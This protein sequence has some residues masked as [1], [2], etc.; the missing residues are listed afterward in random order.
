MMIQS[1][2]MT[3]CTSM[4]ENIEVFCEEN[5]W[6]FSYKQGGTG[7]TVSVYKKSTYLMFDVAFSASM[8]CRFYTTDF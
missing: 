6:C 3:D 7:F 2:T 4:F 5:M 8:A 1:F